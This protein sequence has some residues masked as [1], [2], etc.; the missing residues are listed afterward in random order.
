MNETLFFKAYL[1]NKTLVLFPVCHFEYSALTLNYISC[2]FTCCELFDVLII[3]SIGWKIEQWVTVF[4]ENAV[5]GVY[6]CMYQ[7]VTC[8]C[9]L[10]YT[11]EVHTAYGVDL[12]Q[13]NKGVDVTNILI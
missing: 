9:M 3:S 7:R 1:D 8:I 13:C 10:L 11:P 6:V 2:R 5:Y 4:I 12:C